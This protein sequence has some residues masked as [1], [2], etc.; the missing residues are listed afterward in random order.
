MIEPLIAFSIFL[1]IV[2]FARKSTNNDREKHYEVLIESIKSET[3]LYI[4]QTKSSTLT[5]GLQNG[6][7]L[8]NRCDI[9]L[10]ETAIII[11]GYTKDSFFKLLSSPIILTKEIDKYK[12]KFPYFYVNKVNTISFTNNIVKIDFGG[13]GIMQTEVRIKLAQLS[14]L[15]FKEI[16][17][18]AE[19]NS[20]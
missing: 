8:F 1:L 14:E 6:N 10:T 12:K 9:Y 19:K 2:F 3:K 4:E 16:K 5:W 15:E 13:K 11:L 18:L 17:L 7:F 20:W